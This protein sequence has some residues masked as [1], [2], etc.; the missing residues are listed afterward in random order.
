M[1]IK[2]VFI[3]SH[4]VF[5]NKGEGM[6]GTGSELS[7]YFGSTSTPYTFIKHSL[8][9]GSKT[10]VETY[11]RKKEKAR[12][13]GFTFL[14]LPLKALYEQLLTLY[15]LKKSRHKK[16]IFI[17][18][19]PLNGF[20]GV[21]AKKLGLADHAIFYTADYAY[22]RFANPVMNNIYHWFDRFA[23]NNA[24][25]VW[26]VSSRIMKHRVKQ[27]LRENKLY[28]VPNS[29]EFRKTRRL[30]LSKVNVHDLVIVSNLT[31]AIDY[32]HVIQTVKKLSRKYEDI[33]LLIIGTGEAEEKLKSLVK[34][35]KLENKVLF[36][37]RK[38]HDELLNI[39]SKS[40]VGIALYT[41]DH[42]WTEFGDSMKVRE[43]LACGLPVILNDVPSTADDVEKENVGFVLKG[44]GKNF[45]KAIDELFR[46]EEK[47]KI[48]RKN[49]VKLAK[50]NDFTKVVDSALRQLK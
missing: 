33:R 44:K 26:N 39:L 40:G 16:D 24:D 36:L 12:F 35:L 32:P 41:N 27:G 37:G 42:P 19:D 29:P 45:A 25:Q 50:E 13:M 18:I 3:A 38:N 43:Y 46:D 49:A 9:P 23:A 14:P 17:G 4:A 8:Y 15:L 10:R 5:N 47:Y 1:K 20:T 48:M 7:T 2:G 22:K 11:L 21:L 6:H 31:T 28:L 30:P 34:E